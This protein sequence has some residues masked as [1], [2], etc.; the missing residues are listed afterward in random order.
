MRFYIYLNVKSMSVA[1]GGPESGTQY[2]RH[3]GAGLLAR[4]DEMMR[5]SLISRAMGTFLSAEWSLA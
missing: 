2:H 5:K 3:E 4:T 1:S